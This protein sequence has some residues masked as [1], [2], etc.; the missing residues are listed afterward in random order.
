[1][2]SKKK[3]YFQVRNGPSST[4][5]FLLMNPAQGDHQNGRLCRSSFPPPR[6]T[7][8]NFLRVRLRA[9]GDADVG[10]GFRLSYREVSLG[11]GENVQLRWGRHAF[12]AT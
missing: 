11:C 9:N 2:K 5:P 10:A 7:T 6:N 3:L 12:G 8:S 4:S 1:M